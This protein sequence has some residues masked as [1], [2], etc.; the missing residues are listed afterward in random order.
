[1]RRPI[2]LEMKVSAWGA[3][4]VMWVGWGSSGACWDHWV[5]EVLKSVHTFIIQGKSSPT[6]RSSPNTEQKIN[7]QNNRGPP[8][9]ACSNTMTS[10][11]F[12]LV[13]GR[14]PQ[15]LVYRGCLGPG[16]GDCA[17]FWKSQ[18]LIGS[19]LS[20]KIPFVIQRHSRTKLPAAGE[21]AS[22]RLSNRHLLFSTGFLGE[23]KS[24]AIDAHTEVPSPSTRQQKCS[25][26]F[27]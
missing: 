17:L 20:L 1:M 18:R 6:T 27:P 4:A 23:L 3:A 16:W 9:P 26:I 5:T 22:S 2:W 19:L 14:S 7:A 25:T 11:Q 8:G 10:D 21:C 24:H 15:F 12:W 13:S